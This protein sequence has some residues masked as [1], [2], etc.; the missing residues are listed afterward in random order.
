MKDSERKSIPL[1]TGVFDYFPDALVE[2]ARVSFAGNQKH[3]P[4]EP[5]HWARGKSADHADALLRHMLDRGKMDAAQGVRHSAEVA[6]RALAML[7]EELEQ[8]GE[9]PL[10]RGATAPALCC[11]VCG[12]KEV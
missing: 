4:G 8:A 10:A 5:L 11:E 3:N 7:Q 1:C 12:A 2:V 6:W 9:A